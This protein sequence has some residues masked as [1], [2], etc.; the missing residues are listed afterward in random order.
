MTE[1]EKYIIHLRFTKQV[2]DDE[3]FEKFY[4]WDFHKYYLFE[5]IET[6]KKDKDAKGVER[7]M[8]VFN[9]LTGHNKM[10]KDV[11]IKFAELLLEN[12]HYCHEDIAAVFQFS[13][14]LPEVIP[15]LKKAIEM[16]HQVLIDYENYEPFVRQCM[17]ALS[18]IGTNEAISTILNFSKSENKIYQKWANEQINRN[19]EK[20]RQNNR[21]KNC[22]LFTFIKS[23]LSKLRFN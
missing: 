13:F 3:T 20:T 19:F 14:P 12:W 22:N 11:A 15:F 4:P 7:L 2:I 21:Q 5:E 10:E 1:I 6:L 17:W 9:W 16:K 23:I 8:T 18:E